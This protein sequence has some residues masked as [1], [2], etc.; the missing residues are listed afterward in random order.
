MSAIAAGYS[1]GSCQ[2]AYN[3]PVRLGQDGV[4]VVK[5]DHPFDFRGV[6]TFEEEAGQVL[7]PPGRPMAGHVP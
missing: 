2:A 1:V 6:G 4:R 7:W 3:L 5:P